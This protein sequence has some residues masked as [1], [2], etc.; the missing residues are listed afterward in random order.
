MHGGGAEEKRARGAP[1]MKLTAAQHDTMAE[2]RA[3]AAAA[4]VDEK[5]TDY[6][7]KK[8]KR[9]GKQG[10]SC[11]VNTPLRA[12]IKTWGRSRE[13]KEKDD[14]RAR[15]KQLCGRLSQLSTAC[16]CSSCPFLPLTEDKTGQQQ[17]SCRATR[18]QM[19]DVGFWT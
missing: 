12:A 7:G 18:W 5:W 2:A 6:E 9:Q 14:K 11:G 8:K 15:Q 13:G 10:R 16:F 17:S 19:W 1:R 3:A 4:V